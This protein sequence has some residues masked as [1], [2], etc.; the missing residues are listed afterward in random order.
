MSGTIRGTIDAWTSETTEFRDAANVFKT[1]FDALEA[2]PNTTR[3]ALQHGLGG[4]GTDYFD[5]GTP[6]GRNCFVVWRMNTSAART[7]PYYVL[8]QCASGDGSGATLGAAPGDPCTQINGTSSIGGH[9]VMQ[10]AVGIDGDEN[11]WNGSTANDGTDSKGGSAAL[12]LGGDGNAT[13]WRYPA[14]GGTNVLVF[15]RSSSLGGSE[16]ATMREAMAI[17]WS[18]TQVDQRYSIVMD[19]DN[20]WTISDPGGGGNARLVCA[21]LIDPHQDLTVDRPL[22]AFQVGN[23]IPTSTI[24]EAQGGIAF[25]DSSDVVTGPVRNVRIDIPGAWTS[26]SQ[27][28]TL[29]TPN[30]YDLTPLVLRVEESPHNGI[31]GNFGVVDGFFQFCF[32]VPID[33]TNIGKTRVVAGASTINTWK[34]CMPWDGV[35]IPGTNVTR[36]GITF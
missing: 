34:F 2:H 15:P 20:I 33:S 3:I 13:V 18:N 5:G 7:W 17:F 36:A 27:P 22:V 16:A 23:T 6:F 21:G 29:F 19:D 25:P 28:N 26:G 24:N 1:F 8:L 30:Q 11:P 9:V 31:I 12:P 14:A 32:D 10:F 4:S 35:T